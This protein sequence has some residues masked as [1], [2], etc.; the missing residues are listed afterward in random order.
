M[1]TQEEFV[2]YLY[3]INRKVRPLE[4]YK[5]HH[6]K[7]LVEDELGIKYFTSPS[8]LYNSHP[9]I[10]IAVNKN[11]AFKVLA[12]RIH[13][14]KYDYSL[15][16]YINKDNKVKIICP[17]HGIFLQN[18]GAHLRGKG[19]KA[20]SMDE[21]RKFTKSST[22]EFIEKA[23]KVHNF[24]YDYS[25]VE[26]TKAINK[27]KIIC[28]EHGIFEQVAI[29]HLCGSGCQ[30]CAEENGGWGYKKSQFISMA[31]S[32]NKAIIYIIRF[33]N[34]NENFIK[35]GITTNEVQRRAWKIPYQYEV[36]KEIKGSPE[37]VWNKEKELHKLFKQYR[38]APQIKFG[39]ETECF[40]PQILELM[41]ATQIY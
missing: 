31:E 19:C 18:A 36:I 32:K 40:D 9:G 3:K 22:G 5:G 37:F 35:I 34:D 20:C 33:Y 7:I 21:L 17:K 15:V 30:Q 4:N 28:K 16:D 24:R 23:N 38:Y 39:G 14:G 25:L 10:S 13:R 12:D 1:L 27:V 41:R 6:E 8:A 29:Y 26:Y 11:K 2:K